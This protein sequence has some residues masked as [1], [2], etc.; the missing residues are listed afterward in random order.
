MLGV[1]LEDLEKILAKSVEDKIDTKK[2]KITDYGLDQAAFSLQGTDK[3]G[4]TVAVQATVVA[5]AELDKEAIKKQVAG[6][7]A[8]DAKSLISAN[9]GVTDVDVEYSPFWVSSIPK[10]TDKITVVIQEPQATRDDQSP[11]P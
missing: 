2:Q 4:A 6:K 1:M 11:S 9:V 8:G 5:G 3:E 7:K 10:R